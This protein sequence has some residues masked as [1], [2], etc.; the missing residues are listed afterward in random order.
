MDVINFVLSCRTGLKIFGQIF[1]ATTDAA[2]AIHFAARPAEFVFRLSRLDFQAVPFR[3][4]FRPNG[5]Y[6]KCLLV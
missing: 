1:A 6:S 3:L 4:H 5:S 2:M